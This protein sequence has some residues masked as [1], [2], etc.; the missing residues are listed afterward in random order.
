M[1]MREMVSIEAL[2]RAIRGR[3]AAEHGPESVLVTTP[4]SLKLDEPSGNGS[5]WR[6]ELP[7][8][9]TPDCQSAFAAAAKQVGARLSLATGPSP[10]GLH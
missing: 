9:S 6:I 2:E 5:N 3:I 1:S 10:L 4:I 8:D 7:Q